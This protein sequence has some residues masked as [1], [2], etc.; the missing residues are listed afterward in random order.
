MCSGCRRTAIKALRRRRGSTERRPAFGG[1]CSGGN[2]SGACTPGG[3]AVRASAVG[4]RPR[5][6]ASRHGRTRRLH[7][8]HRQGMYGHCG[9]SWKAGR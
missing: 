4:W 9:R 3:A 5:L 6:T 8:R 2:C 1:S 7:R